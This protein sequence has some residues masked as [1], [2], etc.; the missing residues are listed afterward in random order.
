MISLENMICQIDKI[1]LTG[2]PIDERK[3]LE[4]YNLISRGVAIL[5]VNAGDEPAE[6]VREF[7]KRIYWFGYEIG[8]NKALE[9]SKYAQKQLLFLRRA[10]QLGR[11]SFLGCEPEMLPY[12][13]LLQS[14]EQDEVKKK[15][16]QKEI[17]CIEKK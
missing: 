10:I 2:Y 12:L 13:R 7:I 14:L 6:I 17:E 1:K 9:M 16:I 11:G 8:S 15:I 3:V 4:K 5:D